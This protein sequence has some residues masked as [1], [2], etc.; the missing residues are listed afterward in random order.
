MPGAERFVAL[1]RAELHVHLDGSLRPATLIELADEAGVRIPARQPAPLAR[2]MR[3]DDARNLDDYLQ[4]FEL[5]VALLQTEAA[6]ERVAREMV[7]DAARD[8]VRYLEVRYCP[9]LSRARG[10]TLDRILAAQWRG[11]TRGQQEH[12]VVARIICCTLRHL[13]PR[14]SVEIA[15]AAVRHRDAGVVGFDIAGGEA[16]HRAAPHSRAFEIAARGGLGVT[17]HAG[18]AAG[19]DSIAE[20]IFECRADRIGHGTRLFED[21]ALM[22][23]VRDREIPIEINLTSN[24]QTRVVA[25]A[26]DHPLRRFLDQGLTVVLCADN[27]LMSDVTLSGEYALAQGALGLTGEEVRRIARNGFTSAFL[28]LPERRALLDSVTPAILEWTGG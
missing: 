11:L 27:W 12:G 19:P 13:D 7:V 17:V 21:P 15:E 28:P 18:E 14:V 16:G 1:P 10:L 24:L 4:R 22:A 20:A 9:A 3:V 23:Y 8:G 25:R 26:A 5:T 6:L 2:H